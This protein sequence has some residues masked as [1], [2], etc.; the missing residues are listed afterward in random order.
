MGYWLSALDSGIS[1][2]AIANEFI[3]SQEFGRLYGNNT[4]N[5]QF[6]NALYNNVLDRNADAEGANFWEQALNQGYSR[7][8]IL[9]AF[10]ESNEGVAHVATLVA[11]GVNYQEWLGA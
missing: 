4:S 2:T 3:N 5:A 9:L 8:Q 1:L 6:V 7:A 11:S 10:S